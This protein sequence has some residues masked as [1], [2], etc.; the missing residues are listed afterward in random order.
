MATEDFL[1]AETG[2]DGDGPRLAADEPHPDVQSVLHSRRWLR[3]V[4]M[5]TIGARGVR[6]LAKLGL[7]LQDADPPAVGDATD[8]TIPGPDGE[9]PARRYRPIGAGP[10]PTV[11]FYHGGGFV[12]GNLDSH[13]L[14]CRHLTA[15]SGCEV[16]AVDYR[17]AP[18]HPF[19]AAVED[20][21]AAL[22]WAA[23]DPD[24]LDPDGGLAVAG[25]SAGGNLA[26]V[27]ALMAAER[28]GPDLDYQS[29][30]YPAVG[31]REEQDSMQEYTGYVLSE[32]D[33]RWFDR[34]YYG[35]EIHR[36]NPYADPSRACDLSGVPPA[37][38]VTAGFDPL[39]DGGIAYARRLVGD[40][41]SV[42]FRNYPDMV[43]GFVG[44][45]SEDEDV[46]R[47]HE[48]VADIAADL[49]R[50]LGADG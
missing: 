5:S 43:H 48:A 39:R 19:P 36:R 29:L 8:L 17:L 4:G 34:C 40:G 7:W 30:V 24:V 2:D 9:V 21:Y 49:R 37:T 31:T 26:A 33:I 44:M 50:A 25:D 47:A 15:A 42:R 22:E 46:A 16:V 1:R 3:S 6:L 13:D 11:V 23:A 28:D 10:Y 18:E 35:S 38:V 41:V 12:L 20:A 32:D 27:A 45:L 14:L